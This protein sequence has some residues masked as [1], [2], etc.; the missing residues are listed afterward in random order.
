MNKEVLDN[1]RYGRVESWRDIKK[2]VKYCKKTGYCA[3]DFETS[4]HSYA[5]PAGYTTC[6][7][8]AFQPGY[9]YVIPLGHKESP[10]RENG[11]W[12]KILK[13]LGR[14]LIQNSK[15]VKV[16]HN[17]KFEHKWW[18]KY[19]IKPR[20]VILD[21]MLMKYLLNEKKPHDLKSLAYAFFPEFTNYSIKGEDSDKTPEQ[22]IQ[23]WSNVPL[24]TLAPYN[25]LD[26]DLCLRLAIYL[27]DRLRELGFYQLYRNLL[28]MAS[29]NL[30]EVESRGYWVDRPYLDNLVETY[31]D[32][33][34]TVKDKMMSV[35]SLV[36]YEKKRIK[37]A[38]KKL[39]S[40][41][42][43][44]IDSLTEELDNTS[45]KKKTSTIQRKITNLQKKYDNYAVGIGITK[46][47]LKKLQPINLS[48]VTQ[49]RDFLF[50]D[51]DGLNLPVIA[52]TVDKK[53]KK[54]TN[55]PATDEDTLVQLKSED[56]SGFIEALLEYRKHTK[57]Y[58]TYVVGI[59][60][61]LNVD[62]TLHGSFLIHGTVTG[63]LSSSSPN[64][65]NMPRDTTASDIKYMFVCPPGKVMMQ[66]DYSQAELRVVAAWSQDKQMMEWF[67]TGHDIHLATACKKYN[68]PYEEA[69]KI[70]S[71]ES[72][73]EYKVW[74][75]RRKQAKT[76]GFGVLYQQGPNHLKET[77]STPDHRVS[78]EEALVF[79]NDWFETFPGVARFVKKQQKFAKKNGYV[80]SPFGRKRRL[81]DVFSR[82]NG[83]SAKALRDAVNAP[84]QGTASDFALFSSIL[85][86]EKIMKGEL[87]SSIE[88]IGT[89]HD[90]LMFYLDPKDM[91]T[92]ASVMFDICK[93]PETKK[94]FGFELKGITMAVDF[95]L[96]L[97][98]SEMKGYKPDVDY[99]DLYKECY[100][101]MWWE[102][103]PFPKSK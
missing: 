3:H 28:E 31:K 60:D 42:L 50:Y 101:P 52:Y 61:L 59:R 76:I 58:S 4:G 29:Y 94:W 89:I 63:R 77:L 6:I 90:S 15:I 103:K 13:Y 30:A 38:K 46:G 69:Y 99:V 21:T 78:K 41:L 85:I 26:S 36:R 86:R 98:W 87:P 64:L 55:T 57:L 75:V 44:E 17:I 79:L 2:V 23:F 12:I 24:D 40:D 62:N 14:E 47:D 83:K 16:A 19:G 37:R 48:S 102:N 65:Q 11:E 96:G 8:I 32:K 10:F 66:L 92:A 91:H 22:L 93:N 51:K 34:Q 5:D 56:E 49:L 70:Y 88:Q 39:L 67:N 82:D 1:Y 81:P 53:T 35:P 80:L 18:M 100:T 71:D 72:N 25:A 43:E 33:I 54:E 27:E 45:D 9:A 97:R 95:E 20:G 68:I 7:S 73:P 84:I 74:K